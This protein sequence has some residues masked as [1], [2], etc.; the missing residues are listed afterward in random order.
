MW[1]ERRV[2]NVQSLADEVE[3][4]EKLGFVCMVSDIRNK[5]VKQHIAGKILAMH[6]MSVLLKML[7]FIV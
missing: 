1:L 7:H 2:R 4:L 3:K 6:C 5:V